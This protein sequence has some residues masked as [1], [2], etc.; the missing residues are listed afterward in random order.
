MAADLFCGH[1]RVEIWN[2]GATSHLFDLSPISSVRWK[3]VRDDISTAQINVPTSLCCDEISNLRTIIHELHIYRNNELVWCGPIVL[4]EIDFA[5]TVI[6]AEDILWVCKRKVLTSGYTQAHPHIGNVLDRMDWL[7]EEHCYTCEGD[8]WNMVP[9][10]L[11]KIV[12]STGQPRTSRSVSP[13]QF[14]VWEDFDKYA[15]DAGTDYTVIGRDIYYWDLHHKWMV[16]PALDQSYLGDRPRIAEYGNQLVTRSF[17]SDSK[18]FA[19]VAYSP[20]AQR[21]IYGNVDVLVTT[22]DSGTTD[23]GTEVRKESVPKSQELNEWK[24]NAKRYRKSPPPLGVVIPAQTTLLP[25]SPWSI[26]ELVPGAWFQVSVTML[27]RSVT[28]WQRLHEIIVEETPVTTG[29]NTTGGEKVMFTAVSAPT[30]D[31]VES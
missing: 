9:G 29:G 15:E 26:A 21:N 13:Y 1:H 28:E 3:R 16:I 7:L 19:A 22:T 23:D 5:V 31:V 20:I 27:C 4:I 12:P 17:F 30:E 18:G 10:H 2:R 24:Q 8:P 6:S 25:G 11:H 14:T